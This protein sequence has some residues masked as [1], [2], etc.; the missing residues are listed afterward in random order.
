MTLEQNVRETNSVLVAIKDKIVECGVEVA[1]GTHARDYA[2]KIGKVYEAGKKSQYDEFWDDYQKNGKVDN[3]ESA[4]CGRLWTEKT[5]KP[6]YNF[7]GFWGAA[8]MFFASNMNFDIAKHLSDLGVI[9]DYSTTANFNSTFS[10]SK[11]TRIGVVDMTNATTA[12]N[13]F[14]NSTE[15]VI[16]DK[17][18]L[19]T[20]NVYNN[21]FGGCSALENVI[22]EGTITQTGYNLQWSTKLSKA[23]I[24]SIIN[25]LSTTTSG[26]SV[27]LSKTAVVT[28]F[29]GTT[30]AEWTS[31][32]ATKSNW[33]INLI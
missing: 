7:V 10:Y 21:W 4:F 30:S 15:L 5:F 17:I 33:T 20:K 6:K 16:I 22:F 2:P 14:Y 24:T 13:T 31:L 32:I 26:L 23:S 29:G 11:F 19:P 27:T 28:A 3:Y 8:Q 9:L 12:S 18:I 1:E 25:C